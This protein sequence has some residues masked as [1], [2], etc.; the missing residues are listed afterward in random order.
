[1]SSFVIKL[2]AMVTM[3]CDH[4]G[5]ILFQKFSYFNYIGR[6]SFPL[7]AFQI[8]EGYRHTK[9]K[10]NYLLRL[11]LFGLISQI[12]FSL[13]C[14]LLEK[15]FTLNI[16]FTLF[17]GLLAIIGY[18][19]CE[20]KALGLLLV[21]S[22]SLSADFLHMDY[23][24]WGV[25]LIFLFHIFKENKVKL[26]IGY[27]LLVLAKYLPIYILYHFSY[28]YLILMIGTLIP[29]LLIHPYNGKKGMDTK[30]LL[31]TFYPVHLVVLYVFFLFLHTT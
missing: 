10:K 7:F 3:F 19:Q 18:E 4:L 31:Y 2:I 27:V 23:G 25:L 1:M 9:S 21:V 24:Y 16:F 13:F 26:Y 8:S 6:I 5:Y 29:L 11:F 22:L 30:Y 14:S 17:M 20:N 15:G 28:E 12:P